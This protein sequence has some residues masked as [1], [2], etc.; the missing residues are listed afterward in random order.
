MHYTVG[1]IYLLTGREMSKA[2]FMAKNV[3]LIVALE[4]K[5]RNYR[6]L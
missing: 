5:S 1:F 3:N 2:N 4:E 6:S